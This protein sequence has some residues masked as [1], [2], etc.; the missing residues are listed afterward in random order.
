LL[1][2]FVLNLKY[3]VP[4]YLQR[5]TYF[6]SRYVIQVC[7]FFGAFYIAYNWL[8]KLIAQLPRALGNFLL[9]NIGFWLWVGP[10]MA[11]F[12]LGLWYTRRWFG[13]QLYFLG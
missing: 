11:L 10:L 5:F 4:F 12:M 13:I 6:I 2:L 3:G 1:F 8:E 9:F 7:L